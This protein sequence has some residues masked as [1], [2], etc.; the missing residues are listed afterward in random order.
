MLH[1]PDADDRFG[2]TP[3]R[4]QMPSMDVAPKKPTLRISFRCLKKT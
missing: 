2:R 3:F 1:D 4:E